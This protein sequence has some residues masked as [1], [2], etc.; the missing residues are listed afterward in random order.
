M[1]FAKNR[2]GIPTKLDWIAVGL[3]VASGVGMLSL[4]LVY[5]VNGNSQYIVL[6]VF[7][8]LAVLLGYGD[9]RS[10]KDKTAMGKQRIANH[11][12]NMLGGTIALPD[13][14]KTPPT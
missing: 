5:F 6:L 1:R 8:S 7:G 10:H 13:T 11:L 9:Y 4:S 14:S 2:K 12:T 3:M